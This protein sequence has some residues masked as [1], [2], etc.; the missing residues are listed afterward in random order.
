MKDRLLVITPSRA[1]PEKLERLWEAIGE[2]CLITDLVAAVDD[3]D[4]RLGEYLELR[5][6][7]EIVT[8][9]RLSLTGWTNK[10]AAGRAGEYRFL[11]SLGDD[12]VPRTA[13]WDSDLCGEIEAMGGTG[14]AYARGSRWVVPEAVVMSSDIV[15]A[16]GWMANPACQ[17][18]KIDDSWLQLGV[19]AGCIRYRHDLL[20]E[21][22]Q[23]GIPVD[24][25][26]SSKGA[27]AARDI[28][29]AEAGTPAVM[30]ADLAA[31]MAWQES[32]DGLLADAAKIRAI[33]REPGCY[34]DDHLLCGQCSG[35]GKDITF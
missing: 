22:L 26:D 10:L 11:A 20:I 16:L 33:M 8:G 17:H 35:N 19:A 30:N 27:K 5:D 21:H 34:C 32:P 29:Y 14:F 15:R 28:T 31:W 12:H 9:P 24:W 1:R 18:F 2:T 4:P 6:R 25:R 23:Y 3:D 13:S 7:I